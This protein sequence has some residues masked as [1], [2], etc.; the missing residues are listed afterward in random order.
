MNHYAYGVEVP[1]CSVANLR[2]LASQ[3]RTVTGLT[4]DNP[5]PVGHF[6]EY[7]LPKIFNDFTLEILPKQLLGEKH[8]ETFPNKHLM[9]LREDV[10]IGICEG[11]GQHRFTGAHE[12]SHLIYHEEVPLS[13]ARRSAKHLPAFRNSEWQADTLAAELLMPYEAVKNMSPGKIEMLYGVSRSAAQC[14]RD[15]IDKEATRYRCVKI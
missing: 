5:F 1:P 13:L 10:Y 11:N 15:K 7:V 3:I 9:R 12:C 2:K 14:R 4:D 6:I 8:G